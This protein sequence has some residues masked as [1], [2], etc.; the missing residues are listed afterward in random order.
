MFSEKSFRFRKF[1]PFLLIGLVIFIIYLFF[2]VGITDI[3]QSLQRANLFYYSLAFVAVVLG[4]LFYSLAWQSLLRPIS[5]KKTSLSK[6][7]LIAWIGDFV[8]ILVPA[9]S[10]SGEITKAY[11]MT[12][13]SD[14]DSGKVV[15]SIVSHRI[16]SMA[17]TIGSLIAGLV[18]FVTEYELPKP[19]LSLII[20]VI[21]GAVVSILFICLLIIKE[22]ITQRI[23]DSILRLLVFLS[24]GKLSLPSMRAKVQKALVAFREGIQTLSK[25]PEKLV[26]PILFSISSWFFSVMI[27]FLVFASL[28]IFVPLSIVMIV[29]SVTNAIQT[30]PIGVPGEVGLPEIVMVNFYVLLG[31]PLNVSAANAAAATVLIRVVTLWFKVIVGYLAAQWFG[32]KVLA[33]SFQ[34]S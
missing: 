8:D 10:V 21:S 12:K 6:F 17:V 30:I 20:F 13:S 1:I 9:E 24:R 34:K 23:L 2:F 16:I 5:E 14:D 4:M 25:N 15:A 19:A 33:S 29:Y 31:V 7:F 27:S 28:G 18:L 22:Q 3:V 26:K 11:L 32:I